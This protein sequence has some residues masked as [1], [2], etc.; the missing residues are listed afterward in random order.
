M[1]KNP[2]RFEEQNWK[3]LEGLN[4][5]KTLLFLVISPLEEHG[6][7]L[8]V[9][10]DI[11]IS[12][13]IAHSVASNLEKIHPDINCVQLP[14][15]PIGVAK[16]TAD[17][18]G[19]VSIRKNV[20]KKCVYDVC[21]SLA[22]HGFKYLVIWTF[23]M[24]FK[25]LKAITQAIKRARWKNILVCEPLSRFFYTHSKGDEMHADVKETSYILHRYP[26]LLDKG[27]TKLPPVVS[28]NFET[29][30]ALFKTIKEMGA[31]NGYLGT[32]AKA[33]KQEGQ[34]YLDEAI[35]YCSKLVNEWF[36]G[37]EIPKLPKKIRWMMKFC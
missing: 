37:G 16:P 26:H 6:P 32:P 29:P 20:V 25:H 10:T 7:H 18:P 15:L 4:R 9:G 28:I 36:Q 24:D 21:S 31:T 23:H 22:K 11:F 34:Q 8:P 1:K 14:Y 19:T 35:Q 3:Q 33:S 30:R 5:E 12:A 2:I 13:D 27:Y 17:F